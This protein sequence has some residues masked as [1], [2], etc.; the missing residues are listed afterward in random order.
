MT[1][2]QSKKEEKGTSEKDRQTILKQ[3]KVRTKLKTDKSWIHQ[4]S[5]EEKDE[6]TSP[7]SPQLKALEGRKL[8][9]SPIPDS[10]PDRNSGIFTAKEIITSASSPPV[11]SSKQQFSYSSNETNTSPPTESKSSPPPSTTGNNKPANAYIIRGQPFNAI[12]QVKAPTSFNG[13]QKSQIQART[14]SLPRVPTATGYKMSTEEYKKLAPYN[15]RNKSSDLSDDESQFTPQEQTKRTEQASNV[16]RNTTSKDRSYVI[17]AAKRNSGV[18]TQDSGTPFL[19]KRVEIKDEDIGTTR[20][21]QTLPKTLS[22]Y[23][24]E[25]ASRYETQSKQTSTQPSPPRVTERSP[26]PR[27]T[28]YTMSSGVDGR[29]SPVKPEVGKIAVVKGE[30]ENRDVSK[31]S[32]QKESSTSVSTTRT[33]RVTDRSGSPRLTSYSVTSSI[34]GRSSPVKPESGKVT[35]VRDESCDVSRPLREKA[36]S[37]TV[38]TRTERVEVRDKKEETLPKS[39]DSYL[40]ED[41]S[42][43]ENNW[44]TN[45]PVQPTVQISPPRVEVRD[46]KDEALPPSLDSYLYEDASRFENNW[47]SNQTVQPTLQTSPPRASNRPVSPML[48]AWNTEIRGT[49][50]KP[51]PGK[52]TVLRQESDKTPK[53]T[54]NRTSTRTVTTTVE[55]GNFEIPKLTSY[56]DITETRSSTIQAGPGKITV[57]KK[58]SEPPKVTTEVSS[59]TRTTET[60]AESSPPKPVPRSETKPKDTSRDKKVDLI[61]WT[62]LDNSIDNRLSKEKPATTPIPVPRNTNKDRQKSAAPLI[63]ISSDLDYKRPT[64]PSRSGTTSIESRYR[65]S[66]SLDDFESIPS[67]NRTTSSSGNRN[68]KIS[69]ETLSDQPQTTETFETL[70]SSSPRIT[71]NSENRN[72][73]IS[74]ETLSDQPQPT[75]TRNTE[76]TSSPRPS[77]RSRESN[78]ATTSRYRVPETLEDTKLESSPSRSSSRTTVTTTRSTDPVYREY[79]EDY[80]TRSTRTVSS[81]RENITTTTTVDTRYDNASYEDSQYDPLSSNK[82]VLF[83]K[84]YV[85]TREKSLKSPTTAGSYPDFSADSE[86]LSYNSNSSYLYSSAPKRS[87]E[88]PCTYCGREIKD[89]AKIM[90][91]HLNIYCHEYCFKC[92]ICHKPMGDLIDSLFIHRD[93]VH[94]ESCYEK[95]F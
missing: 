33:E 84:E 95:L 3:M 41:A 16:L 24:S 50:I 70:R 49:S 59:T 69:I 47:K 90:L 25:D 21:S 32:T 22:S 51:E 60:N 31:P 61:S 20:K 37:T 12:S 7:I 77:P 46:K 72:V 27:M 64:Q 67:S 87:E 26:S 28:S 4:G 45:Q 58:D 78:M 74:I 10:E 55:R 75:E 6:V 71:S 73:K 80:D 82:G 62:D 89:C 81:S 54:E 68:V 43:F 35:V 2:V 94:C 13:Y 83:V 15:I 48:T 8:L 14:S 92:G 18:G 79:L 36:S 53:P 85:N 17:S 11:Q 56:S 65:V 63:E 88:G 5:E 19:A 40:Y 86:M 38:N 39:L 52:I 44:K 57:L 29:S 23:L 42:R 66:E 91:D 1:S 9:W 30:S 34:D 76:R 93:V